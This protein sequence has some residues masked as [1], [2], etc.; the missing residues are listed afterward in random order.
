MRQEDERRPTWGR[1][2]SQDELTDY[3]EENAAVKEM[4]KYLQVS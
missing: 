3:L 2:R 4:E 1:T